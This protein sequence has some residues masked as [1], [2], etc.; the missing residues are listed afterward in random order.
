MQKGSGR[1]VIH[2]EKYDESRYYK[3]DWQLA[4][5][6]A[7]EDYKA[8]NIKSSDSIDQMFDEIEKESIIFETTP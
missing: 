3:S 8:G 5:K 7:S 1:R 2:C 4:E 6:Q